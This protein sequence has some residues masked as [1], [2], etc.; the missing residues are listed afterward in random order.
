MS[1]KKNLNQKLYH[2]HLEIT[3]SWR[4]IIDYIFKTTD[5]SLNGELNK[6][7]KF[8]NKKLNNLKKSNSHNKPE[9]NNTFYPL[10]INK[11]NI[12]SMMNKYH[13]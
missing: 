2:L 10:I 4:H 11:T 1:R 13:S 6:K 7:Y 3:N 12:E 5:D 8:L 9:Q